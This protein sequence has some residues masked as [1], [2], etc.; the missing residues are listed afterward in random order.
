MPMKRYQ[1]KYLYIFPLM[2]HR[3]LSPE[4]NLNPATRHSAFAIRLV[5]GFVPQD[6]AQFLHHQGSALVAQ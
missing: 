3:F 4:L 5:Q 2:S 1:M 6:V